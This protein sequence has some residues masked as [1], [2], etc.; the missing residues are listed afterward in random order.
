MEREPM[1]I[2]LIGTTGT[3]KSTLARKLLKSNDR[4]LVLTYADDPIIWRGYEEIDRIDKPIRHK[5]IKKLTVAKHDLKTLFIHL[6]NNF[7]NGTLV[8]DDCKQYIKSNIENTKGMIDLVITHRHIG[9]DI[10]FI[11]HSPMQVPKQARPFIKVAYIFKCTVY[12]KPSNY[13]VS[14]PELF[15]DAQKFI[16]E[17]C[18]EKQKI[19]GLYAII[20]L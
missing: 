1:C 4:V 5:G 6:Y 18:V 13:E 14:D 7:R 15:L 19:Y 12:I 17:K 9:V 8:F 10:M 20:K 16:H 11:V 3:G 2:T